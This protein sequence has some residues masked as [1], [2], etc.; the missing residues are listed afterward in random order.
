MATSMVTDFLGWV[1]SLLFLKPDQEEVECQWFLEQFEVTLQMQI[2]AEREDKRR[3]EGGKNRRKFRRSDEDVEHNMYIRLRVLLASSILSKKIREYADLDSAQCWDFLQQFYA[4]L[5]IDHPLKKLPDASPFF[6]VEKLLYD[7]FKILSVV[8][9]TPYEDPYEMLAI[10][11][12]KFEQASDLLREIKKPDN[13]GD[14]KSSLACA[15]HAFGI[16]F[17]LYVSLDKEF[18]HI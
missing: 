9:K 14:E 2:Q 5:T 1:R 16:L 3:I 12:G 6:A 8:R 11:A 13:T 4:R 18:D 7:S 10:V 17:G 15:Y